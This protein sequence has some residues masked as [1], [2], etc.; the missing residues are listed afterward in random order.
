MNFIHTLSE[1]SV[2]I[3][4]YVVVK[5]TGDPGVFEYLLVK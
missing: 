3:F 2:F 4:F 5:E 1:I